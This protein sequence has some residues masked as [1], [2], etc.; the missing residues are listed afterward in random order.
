MLLELGIKNAKKWGEER[1]VKSTAKMINA[2]GY[3]ID[4]FMIKQIRDIEHSKLLTE[5][6]KKNRVEEEIEV[7]AD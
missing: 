3:A 5:I 1:D 6:L 7:W 4:E 2:L